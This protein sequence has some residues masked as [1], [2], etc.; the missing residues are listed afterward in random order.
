[1]SNKSRTSNVL[2]NSKF[3]LVISLTQILLNFLSRGIFLE[4]LGADVLGLNSTAQN[5]L[6]ILNLAEL[7]IGTASS[8]MLYKPIHDKDHDSICDI[9]SLQGWLY[10]RIALLIA[11]G[12]VILMGFF[13]LIFDDIT[14][15]LWYAFASFSAYLLTSLLGYFFNYRQ[16]ILSANQEQ[17]K[18]LISSNVVKML[19]VILQIIAISY[20]ENG[21]VWWL[22]IQAASAFCVSYAL[23]YA[24]KRS[25]PYIK[26]SK[27]SGAELRRKYPDMLIKIGQVFVHKIT[28]FIVYN[29]QSLIVYAYTSLTTVAYYGNYMLII[30]GLNI[31]SDSLFNGLNA[32]VGNLIA[33]GDRK[34][35]MRV[36]EELYSSRFLMGSVMALSTYILTPHFITIW[37]GEEYIMEDLTLILIL[38]TFFI[39]VIRGAVDFYINAHGLF[40]DIWAPIV[41]GAI[42]LGASILFGMIWGINGVILGGI[43]SLTLIIMGWKPYF[44]FKQ[45]LKANFGIYVMIFIKHTISILIIIAAMYL[46]KI[47]F[48]IKYTSNEYIDFALNAFLITAMFAIIQ[49]AILYPISRG[50]RDFCSRVINIIKR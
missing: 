25:H 44:L 12:A 34:R 4:Y 47:E 28:S 15:P 22:G 7:G 50:M 27:Y 23:H 2:K 1:M 39:S 49:L 32:S 30:S 14:L 29:T 31:L 40:R 11:A 9:L 46:T 35:I 3:A 43:V 16:I 33:S 42:N 41:E 48:Y 19:F 5:L 10:K 21:Y 13:S 8:V 26:S 18:I 24:V 6:S 17:Y 38:I 20:L 45:G 37:I 36:F